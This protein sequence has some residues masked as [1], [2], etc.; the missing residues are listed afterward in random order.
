MEKEDGLIETARELGIAIIA[1]SPLGR[2]VLT[3][4]YVSP[5]TVEVC[6]L[7]LNFHR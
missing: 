1:Y 7:V 6:S 5:L 4:K 3:G 2:G